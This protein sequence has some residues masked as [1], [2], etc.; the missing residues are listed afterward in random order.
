MMDVLLADIALWR[1]RSEDAVREGRAAV[2]LFQEIGDR[3]GETQASAPVVR[4]LAELGQREASEAC[5]ARLREIVAV[6]PVR[7]DAARPRHRAEQRLAPVRRS[8]SGRGPARRRRTSATWR[9]AAPTSSAA[10]G[11]MLLQLGRAEEAIAVF[12]PAYVAAEFDGVAMNMGSRLAL[13]YAVQ[14]Q[15]DDALRVVRELQDRGGRDV[16]RPAPRALGRSRG[17]RTRPAPIPRAAVDAAH[18]IATTT[19]APLE[20]AIA[21][22]VRAHVLEAIG[23]PD[24]AEVRADANRQL[25]ALD[26]TGSGWTTIFRLAL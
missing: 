16:P 14:R 4:A 26:I 2:Q 7:R 19:D 17:A 18:A 11:L 15:P 24:A 23:A 6:P 1:G 21:A 9:S 22:H 25:D 20:H 10:Y 3:W 12:E 8:R 13:A 5:L